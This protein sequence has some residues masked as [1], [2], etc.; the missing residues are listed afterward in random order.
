[1]IFGDKICRL[2]TQ[3]EEVILII[4]QALPII[5]IEIF[6]D[7]IQVGLEGIMRAI[8]YQNIATI[9]SFVACW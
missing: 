5:V 2:Y 9:C 4:M 6:S 7:I 3:N 1:M 8:G